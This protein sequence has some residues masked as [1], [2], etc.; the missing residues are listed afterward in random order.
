MKNNSSIAK[1][2]PGADSTGLFPKRRLIITISIAVMGLLI[3]LLTSVFAEDDK[4]AAPDATLSSESAIGHKAFLTM[5]NELQLDAQAEYNP[6]LSMIQEKGVTVFLEPNPSEIA[7]A[8]LKRRFTAEAALVVLPK[9]LAVADEETPRFIS[10]AVWMENKA[11]EDMARA[12]VTDATVVRGG[13]TTSFEKNVFKIQPLL[14]RPQFI[15]SAK[16]TPLIVQGGDILFGS[17]KQGKTTV[18]ILSDPDLLN[19]HG[20]IKGNNA[21][22]AVRMIDMARNKGAISFDGSVQKVVGALSLWRQLFLP[23]LLGMLLLAVASVALLIW[24]SAQRLLPPRKL[25]FGLASGKMGLVENSAALF[26]PLEHRRFLKQRYLDSAIADIAAAM[27]SIAR[28]QGRARIQAL[29]LLGTN[30][31]ASDSVVDLQNLVDIEGVSAAVAG[32]RIYAWKQ[33]ILRGDH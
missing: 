3:A 32:R 12:V 30:R 13:G 17:I 22:L 16:L 8:D 27:P 31:K 18:Y 24:H 21:A 2:P 19:N 5:L 23:P 10:A 4:S 15:R 20:L 26:D 9:W 1:L 25:D 33:E 11:V 14:S 28:A 29:E 6:I 7:P